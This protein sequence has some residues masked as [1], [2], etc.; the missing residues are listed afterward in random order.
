MARQILRY[1]PPLEQIDGDFKS[2]PVGWAIHGSENGWYCE[3]G[4]YPETLEALLNAGAKLPQ[5]DGG[6]ES[7]KEVLRRFR[8]D[9]ST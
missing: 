1:H 6:T 8:A 4:N 3:S 2:T 9:R 5:K 7:V